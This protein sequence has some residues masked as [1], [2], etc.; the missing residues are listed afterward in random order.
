MTVHSKRIWRKLMSNWYHYKTIITTGGVFETWLKGKKTPNQ[1]S[2]ITAFWGCKWW[3]LRILCSSYIKFGLAILLPLLRVHENF[4]K[5]KW[6][7]ESYKQESSLRHHI[8]KISS[9]NEL[10]YYCKVW[11]ILPAGEVLWQWLCVT[12]IRDMSLA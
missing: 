5:F 1:W 11:A 4:K 3:N 2:L 12:K 6:T 8:H 10:K 9:I 7:A